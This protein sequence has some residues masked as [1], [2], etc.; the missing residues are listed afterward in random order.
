MC[1]NYAPGAIIALRQG[2]QR[3]HKIILIFRIWLCCIISNEGNEE[4]NNIVANISIKRIETIMYDFLWD[5]KP[6]KKEKYLPW[7]MKREG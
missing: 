1:L 4:Y 3:S 7:I 5:S 2:P 6:A